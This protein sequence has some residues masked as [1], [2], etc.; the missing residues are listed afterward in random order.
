MDPLI[1]E[2]IGT[3]WKVD[4]YSPLSARSWGFL[5]TVIRKR[6]D[7]FDSLYSRFRPD[8]FVNLILPQPGN[9]ILPPD[10]KPLFALYRKLYGITHGIFTPLIG[11]VLI[12]AGYDAE[13]S[14]KGKATNRPPG[15]KDVIEFHFPHVVVKKRGVFDFGACGKGYLI[16]IVSALLRENGI[17]SFCI[18]A[19]GDIR[20]EN[21]QPLRVGLENPNNLDQAIGVAT[22]ANVSLCASAGSRRK[23]NEYHHIINP[24]T[25]SSPEKVIATWV[26]AQTTIIADAMATALFLVEPTTLIPHF[27]FEYL[28]MYA[29]SSF[30]K[31]PSFPAELFLK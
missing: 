26:T 25:L 2:G 4:V 30:E 9:H 24:R 14:L 31:S 10:A 18:D 17:T 22:I 27:P 20:Y 7:L 21:K 3:K 12:D 23:W 13:Y 15:L 5:Q 19:G 28:I 1:F 29:D 11:Q 16:D 8:S 6:V